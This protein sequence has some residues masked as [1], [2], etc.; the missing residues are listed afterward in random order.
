[1]AATDMT[2][3]QIAQAIFLTPGTVE[4]HLTSVY[5]KLGISSRHQLAAALSADT[6][7]HTISSPQ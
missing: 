2:N 1:M 4:K 5:S 6:P 7:D 3:P